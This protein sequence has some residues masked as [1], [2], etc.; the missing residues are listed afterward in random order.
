MIS[1]SD[2]DQ[3]A[4]FHLQELQ[5]CAQQVVFAKI[6]DLLSLRHL[7]LRIE[8][9]R[10]INARYRFGQ[11]VGAGKGAA[12]FLTVVLEHCLCVPDIGTPDSLDQDSRSILHACRKPART[13]ASRLDVL[14]SKLLAEVAGVVENYRRDCKHIIHKEAGFVTL[15]RLSDKLFGKAVGGGSRTEYHH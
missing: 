5:G 7:T 4:V 6:A 9:E 14:E 13:F 10:A 2:V 12:D 8:V 1:F 3:I 15:F 11:V